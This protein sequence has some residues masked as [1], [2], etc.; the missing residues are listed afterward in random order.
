MMKQRKIWILLSFLLALAACSRDPKVQA[1]RYLENGNKFFARDKYKEAS[2]MYRRA[3]QKD[4]RFGEAYYR[5]GLT[6]LKLQAYADAAR[7]L[8][9][10]VE[11]QPNNSDAA[12]KLADLELVAAIQNGPNQEALAKEV[13]E[14]ADKMIEQNPKSYDGHRILG[15]LALLHR[16]PPGSNQ[17]I[18]NRQSDPAQSVRRGP[19]LLSGVDCG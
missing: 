5:L 7:M 16:D 8:R 19:I 1:Q 11:L 3:L 10:A 14:L 15:Q 13:K 6:D 4:L 2:I 17:G 9:R 12:T 18:R